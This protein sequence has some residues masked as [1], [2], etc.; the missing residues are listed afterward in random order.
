MWDDGCGGQGGKGR[1]IS[2]CLMP[3]AS[4]PMPNAQ[5]PMPNAQF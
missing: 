4:C 2:Q 3:N 5:C 1:I